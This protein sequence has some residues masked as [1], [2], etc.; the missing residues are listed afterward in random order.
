MR[1]GYVWVEKNRVKSILD[2][3]YYSVYAQRKHGLVTRKELME[4][5]GNQF[6]KAKLKYPNCPKSLIGYLRWRA[7]SRNGAMNGD[8][9]IYFLYHAKDAPK[10]FR[11]GR[12]CIRLEWPSVWKIEKV[13][14]PKSPSSQ[15][16][17]LAGIP[18]GFVHAPTGVIK[19]CR[20]CTPLPSGTPKAR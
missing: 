8:K 10:K 2:H 1:K 7:E 5:Y 19:R 14:I 3:G 6:M 20:L 4:K 12:T 11:E 13:V 17:W 18:H 9:V 15:G 16:L